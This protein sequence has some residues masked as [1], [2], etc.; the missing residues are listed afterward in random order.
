MGTDKISEKRNLKLYQLSR[1]KE[2]FATS[3]DGTKIHF[4]SV[5]QGSPPIVCC[6]GL[7]VSTFFWVYLEKHFE[8]FQQVVTWDYRGHGQSSLNEHTKNYSIQ[9]LVKDLEAVL[10]ALKIKKAIF[11]GHSMGSQVMFEF[12]RRHPKRVAGM[13]SCFGY[14]GHPMDS[15]FNLRF[16]PLIFRLVYFL[17]TQFPKQATA[18]SRFFL[19]NPLSFWAGGLLKVMN[20][21]MIERKYAEQ[22][23]EHVLSRDPL[24]FPTL[25]KSSQENSADDILKKIKVPTLILG[26]ELDQFTPAWISKKMHRL[27]PNSEILMI[28][29]ATHAA[30]VEQPE[31]VNLRIEKFLLEK[32]LLR[33]R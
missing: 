19:A 23:I 11:A 8:Q 12:Y 9:A 14:P 27:I 5:G 26:G 1:L 21:G 3:F 33:K 31:L 6:N 22:Y 20:T 7:S 17:G 25:L 32:K 29:K 28:H 10:E 4:Q 18:I 24:L 30:L 15:F 2:G 16:S 13:I